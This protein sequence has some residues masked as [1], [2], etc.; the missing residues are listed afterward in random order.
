MFRKA[1]RLSRNAPRIYVDLSGEIRLVGRLSEA[2]SRGPCEWLTLVYGAT[3]RMVWSPHEYGRGE[4]IM[5]RGIGGHG[6]RSAP[7]LCGRRC[8]QRQRGRRTRQFLGQ[9]Q[10]YVS[11]M[12]SCT[13]RRRG[14]LHR[15]GLGREPRLRQTHP[16]ALERGAR[17]PLQPLRRLTTASTRAGS[18]STSWAW[19]TRARKLVSLRRRRRR[20]SASPMSPRDPADRP[21]AT[22]TTWPWASVLVSWR[23]GAPRPVPHRSSASATSTPIPTT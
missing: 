15:S 5:R 6:S 3:G 8:E 14:S 17:L 16:A 12:V 22:T 1:A 4:A 2:L 19:A 18:D 21:A 23:A 11:P 20:L 7:R 13:H 10:W 9:G